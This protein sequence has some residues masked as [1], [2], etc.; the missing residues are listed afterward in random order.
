MSKTLRVIDPFFEMEIGDTFTLTEDG[1]LYSSEHNEEFRKAGD[2]DEV[3][4]I[5]N[6][7]FN[8]SVE[9]AKELIKEG[10]LEEVTENKK[11]NTFVNVFDEIDNLIKKYQLELNNID[12]TMKDAPQCMKV[13]KTTVLTNILSVLN[14]LKTLRK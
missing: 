4:A 8:I 12:T 10:Y 13:E 9:Y 11:Q 14:H 3:N 2:N 7:V 6:S 1:K 5:Y